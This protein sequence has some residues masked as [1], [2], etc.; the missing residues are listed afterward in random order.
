MIQFQITLKQMGR[1]LESETKRQTAGANLDKLIQTLFHHS[2]TSD[3]A[4]YVGEM[5]RG[6]DSAIAGKV[7]IISDTV[8]I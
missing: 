3:E 5:V 4:Y 7:Y 6:V 1:A 8:Q 2:M